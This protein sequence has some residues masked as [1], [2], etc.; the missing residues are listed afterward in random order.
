VK[1]LDFLSPGKRIKTLRK[2]LN[3]KQ[4][5]LEAIGVSRN[6]ISMVESDKRNLTGETLK[7]FIKFIQN[8]ANELDINVNI[9]TTYLLLPEK[10]EAKN[11][12]V[13]KLESNL[14]HKDLDELIKIGEKYN[15]VDILIK[16]YF[17]KADLLYDEC[18]YNTAFIYYYKILEIYIDNN[19][20]KNKAFIYTKLTKC[21]CMT[22]SY[23]EALAYSFKS[24]SYYNKFNDKINLIHCMFN[25]SIIYKKL[26]EYDNSLLYIDK[27]LNIL[28]PKDNISNYI[29]TIIVKCKCYAA[30]GDFKISI[31]TYNST[32]NTFNNIPSVSLGYIYNNLGD[33]YSKLGELEYALLYFDKAI[34]IRTVFDKSILSHSLIDKST[35]FIKQKFYNNAVSLLNEGISLSKK[36]SDI[37]YILKGYYL[38][39]D[40]YI[41]SNNKGKL[42][43]IYLLLIETLRGVNPIKLLGIYIK[44]SI[45]YMEN[46]NVDKSKE[47][48]YEAEKIQKSLN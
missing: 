40:I 35:V 14:N 43:E 39:E 29:D 19:D 42:E 15:L 45:F 21:K 26:G 17:S 28:T 12:C 44:L 1:V 9:D 18:G 38:L 27:L 3:I 20:D 16:V 32:L 7:K 30:M 36:H 46:N 48:L 13:L 5:E 33:T 24:Y 41:E 2:Q 37:E 23:E 10:E 47:F 25:I 11:Y 31:D 6:Y 22:L 4:V 34:S 8:R